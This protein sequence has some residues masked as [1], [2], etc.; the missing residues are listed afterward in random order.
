M[1]KSMR[2]KPSTNGFKIAQFQVPTQT[3]HLAFEGSRWEGVEVVVRLG[4]SI[5]VYLEIKA[6]LE[7]NEP[8]QLATVFGDSML[9]AWNLVDEDN[10]PIPTT[11]AGMTSLP[12]MALALRIVNLWMQAVA[13]VPTPLGVTSNDGNTLAAASTALGS[14]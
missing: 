6:L 13:D 4:I 3:A 12:D 9:V 14:P 1:P 7:A 11:G 8:I 10:K 5:A 2:P